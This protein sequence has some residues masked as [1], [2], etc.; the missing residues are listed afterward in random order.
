MS[1]PPLCPES[2]DRV[3]SGPGAT[4]WSPAPG[5]LATM[6]DVARAAGVSSMTVSRVINGREGV[7]QAVRAYVQSVIA[8]LGYHPNEAAR[9]LGGYSPPRICLLYRNPYASHFPDFVKSSVEVAGRGLIHLVMRQ[10]PTAADA[11]RVVEELAST[12]EGF[13]LAP[14]LGE[15]TEVRRMLIE[16]RAPAVAL[17]TPLSDPSLTTIGVDDYAAAVAMTRHLVGLGHR[18]IGFIEGNPQQQASA[19]RRAGYLAALTEAGVV[20]DAQLIA[21]GL[22]TYRSGLD[23][24]EK[25]L[26]L[27]QPPTAIFASNDEMAAATV[28]I[29]LAR[30]MT[31]PADLSVCGFD[32]TALATTIWPA[33]TTVRQ[34]LA[35]MAERAVVHLAALVDHRRKNALIRHA[36]IE[37]PYSIVRRQSDAAPR[38]RPEEIGARQSD[39]THQHIT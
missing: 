28:T 34:P 20:E 18:R 37:L 7:S 15:M 32:D 29:A 3:A 9:A 39:P 17:A 36:R 12:V 10:C 27:P 4:R 26:A 33:L 8:R 24:A 30:G 14:P 6:A 5:R 2:L 22:F 11:A 35:E 25:L 31:V 1:D 19:V 38:S 21:P 23:A 13:I 16:T